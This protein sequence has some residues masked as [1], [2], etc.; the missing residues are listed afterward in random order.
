[1]CNYFL[2]SEYVVM[3]HWTVCGFRFVFNITFS[4]WLF[5]VNLADHACQFFFRCII[6]QCS[7]FSGHLFFH[8]I[9]LYSLQFCN[10]K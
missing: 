7:H 10:Q 2:V 4:V 9:S 1:M 5:A 3:G 8:A 6:L